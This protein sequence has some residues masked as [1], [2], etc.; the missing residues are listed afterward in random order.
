MEV[1]RNGEWVKDMDNIK[2]L[3]SALSRAQ[4]K[5]CNASK[6]S[7]NPHFKSRYA[8]LAQVWDTIR[9]VFTAEGLAILQFPCDAGD[10]RVGLRTV[11]M[12]SSGQYIEER[13]STGLKDPNNP[14][15]LT[16][17]RVWHCQRR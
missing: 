2:E 8:D 1:F 3:A 9:D 6:L 12:H 13:C 5:V 14:Q 17:V 16:D 7:N 15:V 10:T 11:L 4:G